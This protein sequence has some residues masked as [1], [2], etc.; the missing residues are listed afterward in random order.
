MRVELLIVGSRGDDMKLYKD[1]IGNILELDTKLDVAT[2]A[3]ASSITIEMERADQTTKS[4]TATVVATTSKIRHTFVATD[5]TV[6]GNYKF[7]ASVQLQ[8]SA[9]PAL[10]DTVTITVFDDFA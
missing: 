10:G 6:N 1:S 8:G 9:A 3:A 5:L 2:L 7:Q 4:L